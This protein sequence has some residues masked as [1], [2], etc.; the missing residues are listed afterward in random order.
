M[1]AVE[2][3]DHPLHRWS[4]VLRLEVGDEP[5]HRVF[6]ERP[7]HDA[8]QE[9]DC[10]QAGAQRDIRIEEGPVQVPDHDRCPDHDDHG[11]LDVGEELQE[12]VLEEADGLF[13]EVDRLL[14]K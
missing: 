13:V 8:D 2:Q 5:V 4:R 6:R 3:V 7:D 1:D 9:R 11:R 12:I 10:H 14:H